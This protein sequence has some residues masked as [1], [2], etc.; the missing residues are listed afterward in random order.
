MDESAHDADLRLVRDLAQ[1]GAADLRPQAVGRDA[2]PARIVETMGGGQDP[3]RGDQRARAEIDAVRV[4][5][6]REG[7]DI[8]VAERVGGLR[9]GLRL[10]ARRGQQRRRR[11]PEA[12]DSISSG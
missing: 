5:R 6:A 2:L 8:G 3:A 12:R 11:G 9:V 1:P 7:G 4:A 10:R